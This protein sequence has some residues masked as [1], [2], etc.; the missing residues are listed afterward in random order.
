MGGL[1]VLLLM[2]FCVGWILCVFFLSMLIPLL[3]IYN[4]IVG[5]VCL[6]LYFVL[7]KK[8]VFTKYTEGYKHVLSIVLKYFLIVYGSISL[9]FSIILAIRYIIC[10]IRKIIRISSI[11]DFIFRIKKF[12]YI[13][14]NI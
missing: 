7:R 2:M 4:G 12:F 3:I 1:C 9:V 10:I 11:H 5:I 13:S 14:I 8:S 6:I